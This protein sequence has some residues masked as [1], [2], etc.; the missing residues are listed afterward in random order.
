M[1]RGWAVLIGVM[2]GMLAG[3]LPHRERTTVR[4]HGPPLAG[5][6]GEDVVYLDFAVLEKPLG[7]SFF[8]RE[9]WSDTDEEA[10]RADGDPIVSLERKTALQKNG[11]RIGQISGVLPTKL[12][13]ML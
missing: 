4:S 9:L 8:N 3:C 1:G 2:C 10:L 12:Q 11:F 13:D 7:D 5:V 6:V